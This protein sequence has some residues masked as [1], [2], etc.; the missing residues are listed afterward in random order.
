[1]LFWDEPETNLS[2]QLRHVLVSVLLQLQRLGVQ[3]LIATHD[4]SV[5]KE[6][7]LLTTGDDDLPFHAFY[8]EGPDDLFVCETARS[9]S[10]H[11][12]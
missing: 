10:V 9:P 2:P 11:L 3:V 5:L 7:D 6:L 12:R 8:Y 1:M 4:Y